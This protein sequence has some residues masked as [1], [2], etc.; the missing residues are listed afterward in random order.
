MKTELLPLT[1]RVVIKRVEAEEVT[2]GGLFIPESAKEK[3]RKGV[4]VAIA[5][6]K[7]SVLEVGDKVVFGKYA[8]VELILDKDSLVVMKEEDVIGIIKEA[9]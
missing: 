9:E 7:E 4:V 5:A 1:K 2:E 6:D 3:P 8:G